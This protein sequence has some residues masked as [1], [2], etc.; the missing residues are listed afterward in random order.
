MLAYCFP[1]RPRLCSRTFRFF[2]HGS[3]SL[4]TPFNIVLM[5]LLSPILAQPNMNCLSRNQPRRSSTT[6]MCTATINA[7]MLREGPHSKM[8]AIRKQS[9]DVKPITSFPVG[10]DTTFGG[11]Y[12]AIAPKPY[13]LTATTVALPRA[14]CCSYYD[15]L[16]AFINEHSTVSCCPESELS[17]IAT[18]ESAAAVHCPQPIH[19][20]AGISQTEP[21]DSPQEYSAR[22]ISSDIEL[23]EAIKVE[24]DIKLEDD[25]QS[26]DSSYCHIDDS[27]YDSTVFE[28]EDSNPS[29]QPLEE[30]DRTA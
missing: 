7:T 12:R 1:T 24:S 14:A 19:S 13:A 18:R 6:K 16:P 17:T 22:T 23:E 3:T 21:F 20:V 8:I 30:L 15:S 29:D 26:E 2:P 11:R 5:N 28:R 9:Y 4:F 10:F 27:G 25:I